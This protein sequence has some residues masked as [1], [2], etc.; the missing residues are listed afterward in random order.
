MLQ[1]PCAHRSNS[2]LRNMWFHSY[3]MA[4]F[5]RRSYS[6]CAKC[7]F[8]RPHSVSAQGSA[9]LLSMRSF[10]AVSFHPKY[11][12]RISGSAPKRHMC[13][14]LAKRLTGCRYSMHGLFLAIDVSIAVYTCVSIRLFTISSCSQHTSY[15]WSCMVLHSD[16]KSL[17]K[18][19]FV[20]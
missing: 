8:R 10:F 16:I 18:T 4:R 20:H 9:P 11:T 1:N 2:M 15:W 14:I 6:T 7:M 19:S 12:G 3:E 17:T 5:S 13:F